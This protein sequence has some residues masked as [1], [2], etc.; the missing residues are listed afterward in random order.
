MRVFV[1]GA[2]GFIGSVVVKELLSAGH[3]V[4]GLARSEEKAAAL[5]QAGADAHRGDLGDHES[6]IAGAK[7]CDGVVHL[8]FVHD[9][10]KYAEANDIDRQAIEAMM[11]V[12]EGTGKPFVGTSGVA[13]VAT[14]HVATE[15]DVPSSTGIASLR[16]RAEQI[17]VA[18][19]A[20][21]V[22]S[23]VVRLPPTVHGAGDRAFVPVLVDIARKTKV[24]AYVGDGANR[25]PAVHRLDAARLY[26]LALEKAEPGTVHHGVA[27]EGIPLRTIAETIG[28]GLG[29]PVKSIRE[30]DASAHFDWLATF[31]AADC[32]TSSAITRQRLSWE[33]RE[34]GLLTDILEHYVR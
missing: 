17:V 12:L 3:S 8:A 18:A 19:G 29:L 30:E 20:R 34:P 11:K 15:N 24:S 23:S 1:T 13:T 31:V 9:F 33:P 28:K 14:A 5:K 2:T 21:G 10:S 32:L 16:G 7:A 26:R 6:L 25:W 4:L 27:E 22:R